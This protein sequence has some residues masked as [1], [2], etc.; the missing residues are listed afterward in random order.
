MAVGG[1]DLE[2][3]VGLHGEGPAGFVDEGVV[4][5]TEEPHVVAVG[6]AVVSVVL[7]DVMGLAA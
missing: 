6:R 7:A 1:D 2:L 3:L 4:A 5:A